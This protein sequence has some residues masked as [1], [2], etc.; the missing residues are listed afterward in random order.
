ML[1]IGVGAFH[2]AHQLPYFEHLA[3]AGHRGAAVRGISLR[4]QSVQDSLQP[5]DCLFT[6]ETLETGACQVIGAL[7]DIHH[8]PDPV[9]AVNFVTDPDL[10]L[11]TMTVTEKAYEP[12]SPLVRFLASGLE[13]RAE[14]G[15]RLAIVSCDNLAG[16]GD[17]LAALMR[18]ALTG[19][20]HWRW[21]EDNVMFP[22]SMV[23]A[24]TPA[25][26]EESRQRIATSIGLRDEAA[27]SRESYSEWVIEDSGDP[28]LPLGDAGVT[29]V[30][31]VSLFERRKL[32][33]LNASHSLL[34]YAGL[35]LGHQFVDEAIADQRLH[36]LV[37]QMS[38]EVGRLFP[39]HADVEQYMN[40]TLQ[41]FENPAIG[42][43]LQQ[44]A[45]DGSEKMV[46]RIFSSLTEL[47]QAG[48]PYQ[49][50]VLAAAIWIS[51]LYDRSANGDAIDDPRSE[52]LSQAVARGAAAVLDI[53]DVELD[54][55]VVAE[56]DAAFRQIRSLGLA[57]AVGL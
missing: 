49:A 31:D 54:K 56:I 26:T 8:V 30:S 43:R 37:Q 17:R 2:R 23:D 50:L 57:G 39:V 11:V 47:K 24:I 29:I 25:S 9:A 45:M 21:V 27:V 14:T 52:V 5:Q 41:R 48:A 38:L 6:L 44:I 32:K 10:R 4:S 40:S 42:H 12:G 55:D 16:N 20:P 28:G 36:N 46:V 19:S 53:L 7:K 34:A 1:H 13:A 35:Q 18:E 3:E 51:F 15:G 22:N 33:C